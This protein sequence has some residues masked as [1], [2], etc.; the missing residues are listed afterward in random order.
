M[1]IAY[2]SFFHDIM[3]TRADLIIDSLLNSLGLNSHDL[4]KMSDMEII[5]HYDQFIE[6]IY[7][8]LCYH[9]Y[10]KKYL[11][12][13]DL[14]R[15]I[16]NH[17]SKI[18]TKKLARQKRIHLN[19]DFN[20]IVISQQTFVKMIN[21]QVS[22]LHLKVKS[23][24]AFYNEEWIWSDVRPCDSLVDQKALNRILIDE[25]TLV[26]KLICVQDLSQDDYLFL[27]SNYKEKELFI[28]SILVIGLIRAFSP[29][30]LKLLRRINRKTRSKASRDRSLFGMLLCKVVHRPDSLF[31]IAYNSDNTDVLLILE[32][33][34]SEELS[35]KILKSKKVSDEF[36][37][38]VTNPK[39]M[40]VV[41]AIQSDLRIF[42]RKFLEN[43][44]MQGLPVRRYGLSNASIIAKYFCRSGE[45]MNLEDWLGLVRL[46]NFSEI[47]SIWL[48]SS[49]A[50]SDKRH[51]NH[52]YYDY[53]GY[54]L[55][56]EEKRQLVSKLQTT[57]LPEILK[58]LPLH[59][60]STD[61]IK[62]LD[63]YTVIR[64]YSYKDTQLREDVFFTLYDLQRLDDA[65]LF[66]ESVMDGSEDRAFQCYAESL[67]STKAGNLEASIG[68]ISVALKIE[69]YHFQFNL[70]KAYLMLLQS[71]FVEA[72]GCLEICMAIE[73]MNTYV[74]EMLARA[75]IGIQDFSQAQYLLET[76]RQRIDYDDPGLQ[77]LINYMK[78]NDLWTKK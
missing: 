52:F 24:L 37:H 16:R 35:T 44:S 57:S 58:F 39:K 48:Q 55:N 61:W 45:E 31:K 11:R 29:N 6:K 36:L 25:E 54:L 62:Y 75:Y 67:L 9:S 51:V 13:T 40:E 22:Q 17:W 65:Q 2:F 50:D 30:K 10:D 72:L 77:A 12:Q 56:Y 5:T 14:P 46:M 20:E 34:F 74:Y 3:T 18:F 26:R 53:I 64:N 70:H 71:E 41:G 21:K 27:V 1:Q 4:G 63:I 32:Y 69:P 42:G 8:F 68:R 23:C 43:Y 76:I 60:N 7:S 15:K 49:G 28:C 47:S 73:P 19:D 38:Q 33:L 59:H 78:E 66:V